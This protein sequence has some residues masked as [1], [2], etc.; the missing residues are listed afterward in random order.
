[1]DRFWERVDKTPGHGPK[2]ECWL[3]I[4]HL[5]HDGYGVFRDDN[6]KLRRA[7][8]FSYVTFK[9]EVPK[10]I[11][12]CHECDVR[13]CVNPAH[14]WLGDNNANTQDMY[15][16]GR[17]RTLKGS[18]TAQAKLTEDDILAIRSSPETGVYLSQHYGVSRA[19]ISLILNRKVWKHI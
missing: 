3:Y 6:H 13:N 10:G 1:M 19:T 11:N 15:Q 17:G 14:L 5:D 8:K 16:K 4:G 9:G 12:V 7:H 18:E 2:G